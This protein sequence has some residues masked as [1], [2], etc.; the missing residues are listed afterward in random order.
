MS[1]VD[2]PEAKLWIRQHALRTT[3]S[4]ITNDGRYNEGNTQSRGTHTKMNQ[5][6][7]LLTIALPR[8]D[9]RCIGEH[10]VAQGLR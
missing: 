8:R 9:R 4:K 5:C 7:Y 10:S 6:F 2:V 1:W 3:H